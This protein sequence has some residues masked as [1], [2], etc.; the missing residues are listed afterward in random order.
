[1]IH[2]VSGVIKS[3]SDQISTSINFFDRDSRT[4]LDQ[5]QTIDQ[6]STSILYWGKKIGTGLDQR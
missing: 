4:M 2:H 5:T 3:N 6:I 1:M